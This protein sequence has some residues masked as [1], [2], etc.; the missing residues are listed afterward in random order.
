MQNAVLYVH[1]MGGSPEEAAHYRQLFPDCEVHGLDYRSSVPWEAGKEI[2]AAVEALSEKA[3]GVL[4]IANSIGAFF[5]MHARLDG[6]VCEA[7]FISPIVD[8]EKLIEGMMAKAGVTEALL[9]QKGVIE[10][11]TG[12][13]LSWEY[14]RYVRTH[15]IEWTVP[16]HIL[17]ARRDV[18]TPTETFR[19]FAE[20]HG[21]SLTVM[22]NGEHWFH[23][24]EQ[25]RFADDW[26]RKARQQ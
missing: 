15:P 7:F 1:G 5:C 11:G 10:T 14:L 25:M 6:L 12:E 9:E 20:A 16:T 3:D 17:C 4:L 21:A 22:E 23:T 18:F 19:A 2:R 24:G 8:M 26:I 13:P